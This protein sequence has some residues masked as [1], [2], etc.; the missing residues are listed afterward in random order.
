M[1]GCRYHHKIYSEAKFDH[2][3][4]I[5]DLK[6]GVT[7]CGNPKGVKTSIATIYIVPNY[8]VIQSISPEGLCLS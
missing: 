5:F 1:Q 4:E 3:F 8:D 6:E 7:R 2:E